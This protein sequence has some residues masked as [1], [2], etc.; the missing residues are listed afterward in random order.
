MRGRLH[1][2]YSNTLLCVAIYARKGGCC[3]LTHPVFSRKHV[4][5][6]ARK[7][8]HKHKCN[9]TCQHVCRNN[10]NMQ[11]TI[12]VMLVNICLKCLGS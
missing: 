10:L 1:L 5:E 11:V 7:H 9:H 3:F 12:L 2:N 4:F 8:A 6:G